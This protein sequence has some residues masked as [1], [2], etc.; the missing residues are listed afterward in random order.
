MGARFRLKKS[1]S[2]KGYSKDAKVVVAAMKTY[3]LVLAD[4]GSR[5]FCTG[6]SDSRWS[7]RMISDLKRIPSSA[8]EAVDTGRL[9]HTRNSARVG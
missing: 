7:D 1:F 2:T 8:F 3:G 5:W 4:N 6:E 9:K